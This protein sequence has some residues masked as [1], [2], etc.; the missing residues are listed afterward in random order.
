LR[1]KVPLHLAIL[2]KSYIFVEMALT[3]DSVRAA[4]PK[5]DSE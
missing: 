3:D 1:S 2:Y 4:S 5:S